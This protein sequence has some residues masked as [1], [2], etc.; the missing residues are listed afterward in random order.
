[1]EVSFTVVRSVVFIVPSARIVAGRL[2]MFSP[3][4][5]ITYGARWMTICPYDDIVSESGGLQ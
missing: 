5:S 4:C 3:T 2:P 1:M